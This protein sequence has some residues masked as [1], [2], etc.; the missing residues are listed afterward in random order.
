MTGDE[1]LASPRGRG[2]FAHSTLAAF[3]SLLTELFAPF[4]RV[5]VGIA[6]LQM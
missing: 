3:L 5:A 4:C 6:P 2:K 1:L